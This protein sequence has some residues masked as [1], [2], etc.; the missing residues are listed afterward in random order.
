MVREMTKKNEASIFREEKKMHKKIEKIKNH[1]AENKKTYIL[2]ASGVVVGALGATALT[3]NK[4]IVN[5]RPIQ[6]LT[7]KSKQHIEVFVEALG[8]PG[9]IIQDTTTGIVYAS[10]GQAARELGLSPSA[11]SQQL[12]GKKPHVKNHVFE[13]LGKANVPQ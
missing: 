11:I 12:S 13:K 2:T 6:I 1:L 4:S 3:S 10:Q 7:W 5:V 9:N 8:D